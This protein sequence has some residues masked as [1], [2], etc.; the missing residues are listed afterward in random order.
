[1]KYLLNCSAQQLA[2]SAPLN[3]RR[4]NINGTASRDPCTGC[5]ISPDA[6]HWHL[7]RFCVRISKIGEAAHHVHAANGRLV[8]GETG[9]RGHSRLRHRACLRSSARSP[10]AT[11][12]FASIA[13]LE[14]DLTRFLQTVVS[15]VTLGPPVK[16]PQSTLVPPT[17]SFHVLF[18]KL[19][20][21]FYRGAQ[22]A[23]G[24]MAEGGGVGKR[25]RLCLNGCQ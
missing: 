18:R 15:F 4:S 12:D 6:W 3:V 10:W 5:S 19:K 21:G 22:T 14:V 25:R 20:S 9:L 24:E 1:M 13:L 17:F 11:D 16:R 2:V 23:V 7:I 8:M